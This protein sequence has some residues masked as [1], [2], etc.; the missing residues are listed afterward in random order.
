MVYTAALSEEGQVF[1]W[2]GLNAREHQVNDNKVGDNRVGGV[3]IFG[4]RV[5]QVAAR[6]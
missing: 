4:A 1:A 2:G 6:G 3:E 5:V